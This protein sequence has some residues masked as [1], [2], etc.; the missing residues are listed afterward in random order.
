MNGRI[1]SVRFVCNK[2]GTRKQDTRDSQTK[3]PRAETRTYCLSRMG[4]TYDKQTNTYKLHDFVPEHNHMLHTPETVH[5]M[6]SQRKITDV[7]AIEIDL[8]DDSGI[9]AKASYELMSRHGG[10][11]SSVGC[12]E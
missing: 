5:M 11:K 3:C 6:S 7:Q 9:K 2:E 12:W 8:A 10:G 4:I 1:S